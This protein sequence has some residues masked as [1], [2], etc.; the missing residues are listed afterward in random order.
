M[1][2]VSMEVAGIMAVSMEVAGM[3]ADTTTPIGTRMGAAPTTIAAATKDIMSSHSS[4]SHRSR[5]I[6]FHLDTRA[7]QMAP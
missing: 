4:S 5:R 1:V 6:R 3:V 2:A 7:I